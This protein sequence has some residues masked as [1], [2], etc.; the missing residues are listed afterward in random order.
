MSKKRILS[1]QEAVKEQSGIDTAIYD[2]GDLSVEEFMQANFGLQ[3]VDEP[4]DEPD[5]AILIDFH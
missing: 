1:E 2:R 5:Q 3:A 4:A